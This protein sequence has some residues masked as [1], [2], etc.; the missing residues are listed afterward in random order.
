MTHPL[1]T[2]KMS[3]GL[4]HKLVTAFTMLSIL[5]LA[6]C[7]A[8][9]YPGE[10]NVL[11]TAEPQE[12]PQ[13]SVPERPPRVPTICLEDRY[14]CT[15]IAADETIKLGFAG[16]LAGS[17]AAADQELEAAAQTAVALT[18]SYF[19]WVFELISANTLGTASIGQISAREW[20]VSG[21]AVVGVIG[22]SAS[23]EMNAVLPIYSEFGV[24]VMSIACTDSELS[25]LGYT[26][27]SRLVYNRDAL[28]EAEA[29][30]LSSNLGV[31]NILIV[32]DTSPQG[33]ADAQALAVAFA[34]GGG[35]VS[36]SRLVQ[37]RTDG[38]GYEVA[39]R[40]L[41]ALAIKGIYYA[42]DV[43]GAAALVQQ[44]IEDEAPLIPLLVSDNVYGVGLIEA[45]DSVEYPVYAAAAPV[46][47]TETSFD[48]RVHFVQTTGETLLTHSAFTPY[49]FDAVAALVYAVERV[50]VVG[51]DGNLYVPR[52]AMLEELRGLRN[53]QGVGGNATCSAEG[54]CNVAGPAFYTL[55]AGVWAQVR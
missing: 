13:A 40:D 47:A 32:H 26:V 4:L 43:P 54:E 52:A 28:I 21:P 35:M 34:A 8:A 55:Q 39:V 49:A 53:F 45:L 46:S 51:A 30:F 9:Q 19:G 33:E 31:D 11:P 3:P 25:Q 50:A 42:G 12:P 7:Q 2:D 44:L 37:P 10:G 38:P 17:R 18:P 27:F 41:N 6:A 20:M 24:P 36:G 1:L 48:L 29:E 15:V 5:A 23:A 14:G 16:T 22:H